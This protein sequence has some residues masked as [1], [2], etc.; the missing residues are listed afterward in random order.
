MGLWP[1]KSS[2]EGPSS[3]R[4]C[5]G[6]HGGST[7]CHLAGLKIFA[8]LFWNRKAGKFGEVILRRACSAAAMLAAAIQLAGQR[9]A[10]RRAGQLDIITGTDRGV[11]EPS[12][13][14]GQ[15]LHSCSL[16]R[17]RMPREKSG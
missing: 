16:C 15:R 1:C 17:G 13:S 10:P 4:T 2:G 9:S 11:V 3:W 14:G 12:G 7:S 8:H 5:T 6:C